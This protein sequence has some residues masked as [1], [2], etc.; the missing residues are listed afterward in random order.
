MN[1][2]PP[3]ELVCPHLLR[4]SGGGW[5][6]LGSRCPGCASVHFPP[7]RSC[8]QCCGTRL[9]LCEIGARGT[10]WSWTIQGFLPKSPYNGGETETTFRPYGVGYI[11]MPA[12]LKVESRLMTADP[13]R[14]KIGMPMELT[15]ESYGTGERGQKRV[16]FAFAP[17]AGEVS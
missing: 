7:Q 12:G 1:A 3:P 16:T 5:V 4:R 14:L 15:L 13:A 6:L 8:A 17:V 9:E 11:E 2:S 10:L